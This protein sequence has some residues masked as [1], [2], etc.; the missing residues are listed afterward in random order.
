MIEDIVLSQAFIT[1]LAG[2][3]VFA[4]SQ[5]IIIVIVNPRQAYMKAA[6]DLSKEMLSLIHKCANFSLTD[7]EERRIKDANA[8]YLAAVWNLG[9][10]KRDREKLRNNG[11]KV[12]Q[13]INGIASLGHAAKNNTEKGVELVKSMK[14]IQSL[15]QNLIIQYSQPVN[16]KKAKSMKKDRSSNG[17]EAGPTSMQG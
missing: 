3:L 14:I 6:S 7:D 17:K 11:F 5:Y 13:N 16:S 10:N 8:A 9:G 1:V 12:S 15:D 2:V 4:I